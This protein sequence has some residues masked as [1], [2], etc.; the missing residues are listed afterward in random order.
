MISMLGIAQIVSWGSLFYSI[1]VLGPAMRKDL[2]VSELFLFTTFTG[3]LLV[4]GTLAPWAGRMIDKRGGR[5]VLSVGSILAV[6]AFAIL[7]VANHPAVLVTG[8]L[9]AGAAMACCLYDPAF[10]TL[11]QHTGD[12]YRKAVTALTL[13]GGFA[14]TVFWP[15][16]HLLLEAW[17]WR[18]TLGIYAGM[19][20]FMCLPIHRMF[21]PNYL[22]KRVPGPADKTSAEE[23]SPRTGAERDS[24][25]AWLTI[26]FAFATFVFGVI[27]VHLIPL[28]TSAGLT[29]AQAVTVS[30]L[31]G[32]MQVAGR[33][34]ELSLSG[35]VRAVTV[36]I[37]AFA[38][39]LLALVALV[40]VEGFG[41]AAIVFV[42]AYGC[43][44]GVLTIVKGTAPAEIFGREGLG[45]LLGHLSS[46]G[47]Y[48]K[49]L[50]PAAFSGLLALGL[51]RNAAL[52]AV[53]MVAMGAMAS[54]VMALRPRAGRH[55]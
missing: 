25:L 31:V 26:S 51:T 18:A 44:N 8:W 29:P 7:A 43:G 12:R 48:A 5:F 45:R 42:V 21:V 15:L 49:A 22:S 23:A 54:Y 19:H 27:A 30:M 52:S 13:F 3:S 24:R 41:I 16:S 50:A 34:I 33:V 14:S 38:L 4:S 47:F 28:L 37:T 6:I 35:R 20:A 40:S 46:A 9:V 17:G 2:D 11:S 53:S 1:G 36:G 10:A 39:M 32:P 55:P